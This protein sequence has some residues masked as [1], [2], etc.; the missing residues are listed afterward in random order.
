MLLALRLGKP[1]YLLLEDADCLQYEFVLA[2]LP[3]SHLLLT[4][5]VGTVLTD[6]R[7]DFFRYPVL[8][9]FGLGLVA[10]HDELVEAGFGDDG[11]RTTPSNNQIG[12]Y[13][14]LFL[15]VQMA[16][17]HVRTPGCSHV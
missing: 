2:H 13:R 14:L 9:G 5:D 4:H 10:T 15:A 12:A 16:E 17:V 6:A 11:Q 7:E 3:R 8:E 1:I